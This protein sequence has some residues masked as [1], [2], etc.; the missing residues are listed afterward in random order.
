MPSDRP[1]PHEMRR[2]HVD[3][4]GFVRAKCECGWGG[5]PWSRDHRFLVLGSETRAPGLRAAEIE[6]ENHVATALAREG[7]LSVHDGRWLVD[8]SL[9][10]ETVTTGAFDRMRDQG[11]IIVG[12]R[13]SVTSVPGA[14]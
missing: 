7:R 13:G 8:G 3:Q 9:P 10:D 14:P 2:R 1:T 12:A 5:S 11:W 4:Y 6:W